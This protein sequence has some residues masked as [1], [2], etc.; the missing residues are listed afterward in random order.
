MTHICVSEL[1]NIGSD[2]GLS[3]GARQAIIWNNIV[4]LLIEPLG[5]NVSEL[6]IGIQ[7]FFIQENALEHVVCEMASILSRP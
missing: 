2:N 7:T 1:T 3:P 4:L 6:S 5:T